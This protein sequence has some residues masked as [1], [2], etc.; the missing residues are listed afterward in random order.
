[1]KNKE[2]ISIVWL[3][4]DLRLKDHDAIH[5]AI[6]SGKRLLLLYVFENILLEDAHYNIRHWNFVKQSL[7]DINKSLKPYNTKVLVVQSDINSVCN[8]HGAL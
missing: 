1:M 7:T 3:K 4:R 8:H 5:A 2:N 6:Q